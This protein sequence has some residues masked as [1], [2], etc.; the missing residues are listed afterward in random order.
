MSGSQ[1]PAFPFLL[2]KRRRGREN[3]EYSKPTE[4]REQIIPIFS[5]NIHTALVSGDDFW[6]KPSLTA[7]KHCPAPIS[8]LLRLWFYFYPEENMPDN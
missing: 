5:P 3:L 2:L 6:G 7:Q 1:P 4:R 8:S